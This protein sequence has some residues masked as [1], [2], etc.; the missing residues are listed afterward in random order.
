MV[1]LVKIRKKAKRESSAVADSIPPPAPAPV[2]EP[3]NVGAPERAAQPR[4]KKATRV[5]EAATAEPSAAAHE[6]FA[7]S[8]ALVHDEPALATGSPP[9]EPA[10]L[11]RRVAA[12]HAKLDRFK[13]EAGKK[14]R[15][16]AVE[17]RS[18]TTELLELLTLSIAGEQYA[19][20]IDEIVEIVT[21][22]PITRVPNADA[23]IVGIVSLR[24]TIVTMLDLRARLRHPQTPRTADTRVIVI[25][26]HG[27]ALG[28]EVD[29][30]SR[31]I[32]VDASTIEPAPV[33]HASELTDAIRGVFRQANALLIFLDLEK[34]LGG[35]TYAGTRGA[36]AA[37][38]AGSHA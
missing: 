24:G 14:R 25:D 4:A 22:R 20:P 3:E 6:G 33:A 2:A 7:D 18:V 31:V 16:F 37:M 26:H 17:A 11:E 28:F 5:P 23:A 13:Q 15:V 19:V 12:G 8:P 35:G 10:T 38:A 34:L 9:V 30:V 29:R 27:E 36:A 32:K 21:P 1:D